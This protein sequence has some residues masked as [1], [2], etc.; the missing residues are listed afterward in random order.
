MRLGSGLRFGLRFGLGL[1]LDGSRLRLGSRHGVGR[2][3]FWSRLRGLAGPAGGADFAGV[4]A[5]GYLGDVDEGGGML[6][7]EDVEEHALGDGG[8]E[9]A[10]VVLADQNGHGFDEGL[11]GGAADVAAVEFPGGSDFGGA[12]E[13]VAAA[14]YGKKRGPIGP[15][16]TFVDM[17]LSSAFDCAPFRI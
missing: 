14:F 17:I 5:E 7:G 15:S 3:R 9:T 2:L 4:G 16:E 12:F 11:A 13:G 10:D 8:D 1:G 6:E